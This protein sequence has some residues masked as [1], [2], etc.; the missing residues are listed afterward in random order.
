MRVNNKYR[1][2]PTEVDG[3]RF[4]SKREA[5]RYGQLKLLQMGGK[6]RNL[7]LQVRFRI[8]VKNQKICDYVADFSYD[9]SSV[10]G[11]LPV[12]EDVK[13][14]RTQIYKLKKKLMLAVHGI[15]IRET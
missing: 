15:Q 3:I 11:W 9:E 4:A 7:Q 2:Q 1:N 10:D 8:A 13:G 5:N 14:V 12:V 6:I